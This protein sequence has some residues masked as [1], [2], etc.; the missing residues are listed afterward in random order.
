MAD[1]DD[2]IDVNDL[3]SIDALLDEA[4]F[5]SQEEPMATAEAD[6]VEMDEAIEDIA[7]PTDALLDDLEAD[8]DD[9]SGPE[10]DDVTS[11][12]EPE[13][14]PIP[15]P[16]PAPAPEPAPVD[17]IKA[18]PESA[19]AEEEFLQKRMATNVSSN[20]NEL[21]VAEMDAIKKL[22]IIFSSVLIVLALTGIGIGVWSALASGK[23][24][25]EESA[26]MLE[27]V[28]VGTEQGLSKANNATK[29][30]KGMEKKLDALS[31]QIEQ[32][33]NDLAE[34]EKH[35]KAAKSAPSLGLNLQQEA[36]GQQVNKPV[37]KQVAPVVMPAKQ[38]MM[39]PAQV[40]AKPDPELANKLKKVNAQI[41][42]AQKYIKE[43]NSRVKSLQTQYK[44]LLTSVKKVE[45]EVIAEKLAKAKKAEEEQKAMEESEEMDMEDS[46][47][48]A[49]PEYRYDAKDKEYIW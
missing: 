4:E 25:D 18:S 9:I 36:G 11:A 31:F 41:V 28:K 22:I 29:Q 19:K 40:I 21:T 45:K 42:K 3:D 48:G 39:Q 14:E 43:V 44:G 30:M 24:L 47:K 46:Q 38:V 8:L 15:E 49:S 33:N 35:T 2:A 7:D 17:P 34:L 16:D 13:P 6:P 1:Q 10:L 32:L 5:E 26:Q 27:E 12:L 23:G 20:K 37:A